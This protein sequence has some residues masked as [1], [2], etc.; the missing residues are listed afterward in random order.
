MLES[1][2]NGQ[3]LLKKMKNK[4][5]RFSV[6]FEILMFGHQYKVHYIKDRFYN[7]CAYFIWLFLKAGLTYVKFNIERKIKKS[8]I[9]K[10]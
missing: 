7:H 10:L 1:L 8:L 4:S 9:L 6:F 2:P 3:Y 5:K